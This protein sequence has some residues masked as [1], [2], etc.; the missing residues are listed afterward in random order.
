MIQILLD[1]QLWSLQLLDTK[2]I[3][4][5]HQNS[6]TSSVVSSIL[7]TKKTSSLSFNST[8]STGVQKIE[9]FE[10]MRKISEELMIEFFQKRQKRISRKSQ[11]PLLLKEI[12]LLLFLSLYLDQF[13]Q[14][15]THLL[16]I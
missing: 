10:K 7:A 1:T 13:Q 4:I 8:D 11:F 2:D 14:N 9:R 16:N 3:N 15:W 6:A 12:G 5:W